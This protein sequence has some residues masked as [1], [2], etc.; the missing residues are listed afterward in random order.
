[1]LVRR[2]SNRAGAS[3]QGGFC[4]CIGVFLLLALG[5]AGAK[6]TIL[7][8]DGFEADSSM[9]DPDGLEPLD[10]L[11]DAATDT[12]FA[13]ALLPDT[14]D[15]GFA[16]LDESIRGNKVI[17]AIV[18]DLLPIVEPL[19]SEREMGVM[20][21]ASATGETNDPRAGNGPTRAPETEIDQSVA[22]LDSG[23]G[24]P[25]VR[26]VLQ[27]VRS[28][29]EPGR[30]RASALD[31]AQ[32]DDAGDDPASPPLVAGVREWILDSQFLGGVLQ[33]AI[34]LDRLDDT[35]SFAG[36][37]SF[38]PG[39]E[40]GDDDTPS[41]DRPPTLTFATEQSQTVRYDAA[42]AAPGMLRRSPE[43]IDLLALALS[44]VESPTGI[45]VSILA[46]TLL[47]VLSMLRAMARPRG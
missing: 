15:E 31:P 46:G 32:L 35:M 26:Q 33:S 17:A 7:P 41:N 12:A 20:R 30:A 6:A 10:R 42:D 38:P 8:V 36:V 43:R 44:Y 4:R 22:V 40:P 14:S 29:A 27:M 19:S 5:A 39:A 24:G 11:S 23:D 13:L 37:G 9:L 34:A 16:G 1:M 21:R 47:V 3:Y 45:M 18:G 2:G 28:S 25:T